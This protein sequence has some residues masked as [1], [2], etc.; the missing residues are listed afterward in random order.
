MDKPIG[1]RTG[2]KFGVVWL[3][4]TLSVKAEEGNRGLIPGSLP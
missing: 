2:K 3:A 1:V 4:A